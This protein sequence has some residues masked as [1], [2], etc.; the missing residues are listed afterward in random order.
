MYQ[1]IT[2]DYILLLRKVVGKVMNMGGGVPGGPAEFVKRQ[3]VSSAL[4]SEL[5]QTGRPVGIQCDDRRW[6][7]RVAFVMQPRQFPA[8]LGYGGDDQAVRHQVAGFMNVR[9]RKS[10]DSSGFCW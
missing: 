3:Q 10:L 1:S 7:Q 2:S 5:V 6:V 8:E 9:G 4:A